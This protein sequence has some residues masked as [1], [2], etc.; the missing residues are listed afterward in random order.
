MKDRRRSRSAPRR[1]KPQSGSTEQ[2]ARAEVHSRRR[3]WFLA[4]GVVLAITLAAGG[5]LLR[6]RTPTPAPDSGGETFPLPPLSSSP[7]L[8]TKADAHYVGSAAC[9]S[10]HA[11]EEES[12]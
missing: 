2:P 6:A 9:R 8:N 5:L 12:F 4:A 10:C 11:T 1:P 3:G 7:F